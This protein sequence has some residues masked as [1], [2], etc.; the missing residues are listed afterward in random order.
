MFYAFDVAVVV[1]F[2]AMYQI[3]TRKTVSH[4]ESAEGDEQLQAFIYI[5]PL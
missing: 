4:D 1:V 3:K 5:Q 2:I